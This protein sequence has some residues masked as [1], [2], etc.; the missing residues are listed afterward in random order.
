MSTKSEEAI[1]RQKKLYDFL[2]QEFEKDSEHY[3][4]HLEI[5]NA[6]PEF[7]KLNHKAVSKMCC[8]VIQADIIRINQNPEFE[9]IIL[10][11]NQSYKIASTGKE[12]R[13]FLNA[14]YVEKQ[15]RA[16]NRYWLMLKKVRDDGQVR[17]DTKT[18]VNTFKSN[19]E[20]RNGLQ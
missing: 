14:K 3:I 19:G 2:T 13:D 5:C 1:E 15:K 16:W 12:A 9:N 8:S 6:L 4:T 17:L 18:P 10:F 11:K 20:Q 7:Y